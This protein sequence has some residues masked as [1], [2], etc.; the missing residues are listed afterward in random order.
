MRFPLDALGCVLIQ[1]IDEY[2]T[3]LA[4]PFSQR[5]VRVCQ[6]RKSLQTPGAV[7][8]AF[9]VRPPNRSR[10]F[11]MSGA[12]RGFNDRPLIW[13][14]RAAKN[15]PN[16]DGAI[17]SEGKPRGRQRKDRAEG[18]K[19][20]TCSWPTFLLPSL[21][22]W[23][24]RSFLHGVGNGRLVRGSERCAVGIEH[25]GVPHL[26]AHGGLFRNRAEAMGLHGVAV[27]ERRL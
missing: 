2:R 22:T 6:C 7:C 19:E 21:N 18:G 16:E 5:T 8:P 9:A 12:R 24:I 20:R 14:E 1:Q 13:S 27:G 23:Q 10:T 26:Y 4:F 17:L 3:I 11:A 15:M 25:G